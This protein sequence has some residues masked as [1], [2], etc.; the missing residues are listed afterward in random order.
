MEAMQ[1]VLQRV[2]QLHMAWS[3]E[4]DTPVRDEER[5]VDFRYYLREYWLC[6]LMADFASWLGSL[7]KPEVPVPS[8]LV[9]STDG[10]P[11]IFGGG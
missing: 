9:A 11:I 4:P 10:A 1:C 5:N 8:I 2:L 6:M 7:Q 3:P